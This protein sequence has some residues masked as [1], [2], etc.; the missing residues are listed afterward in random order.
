MFSIEDEKWRFLRNKLSP[1]FTSGKLKAMYPEIGNKVGALISAIDSKLESE[2]S[3]ELK[4]ISIRFTVDVLSSVAFGM[5]AKTLSG[6]NERILRI[7][8]EIFPES[9][10]FRMFFLTIATTFPIIAKIFNVKVLSEN[11]SSFFTEIVGN[12][13]KYREESKDER[14]DVLNMLIQLK[15]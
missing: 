2:S 12:N 1:V 5:E 9:G 3:V 8:K 15:N 4:N 14:K 7:F 10:S 13:I 11:I 6:E